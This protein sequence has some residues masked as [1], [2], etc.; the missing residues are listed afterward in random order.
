[1]HPRKQSIEESLIRQRVAFAGELQAHLA[2]D[3]SATL[4]SALDWVKSRRRTGN[5]AKTC[6]AVYFS[7]LLKEQGLPES[8]IR[9]TGNIDF[10]LRPLLQQSRIHSIESVPFWI[11]SV[12]VVVDSTD[13]L[14]SEEI[15]ENYKKLED[16]TFQATLSYNVHISGY[17]PH[18][19]LIKEFSRSSYQH[20]RYLAPV[21]DLLIHFANSYFIGHTPSNADKGA[22]GY[23]I[24][25]A[26]R[27]TSRKDYTE[28]LPI[29]SSAIGHWTADE[30]RECQAVW[31]N[32][33]RPELDKTSK[34]K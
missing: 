1:M 21:E 26:T 12:G 4:T 10:F 8:P 17:K 3:D 34:L 23:V 7:R 14:A 20:P 25:L 16:P 13:V 33:V 32:I 27:S 29:L 9:R 22:V 2:E 30:L 11:S 24:D 15:R 28:L 31:T 6:P 18:I 5:S 19:E